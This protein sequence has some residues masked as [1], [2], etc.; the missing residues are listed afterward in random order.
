MFTI[1]YNNNNNNNHS[2][3]EFLVCGKSYETAKQTYVLIVY[4]L[5]ASKDV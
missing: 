1:N 2:C 5:F 3:N 4:G